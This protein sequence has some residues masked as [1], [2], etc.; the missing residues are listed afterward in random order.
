M[1]VVTKTGFVPVKLKRASLPYQ[2]GEIIGL[3]PDKARK[4][5]ADG[6]ADFADIPAGVETHNV[7][8]LGATVSKPAA[9]IDDETADIPDGWKDLHPL[10]RVNLAKRL[11]PDFAPKDGQTPTEAADE[12]LEAELKRRA[13]AAAQTAGDGAQPQTGSADGNAGQ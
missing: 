13:E 12:F 5:V 2:A 7:A 10:K 8:D 3:T 11:N 9:K 1:K 6:D 4:A